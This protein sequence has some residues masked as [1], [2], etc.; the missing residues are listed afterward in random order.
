MSG[1]D[2]IHFL[3]RANVKIFGIKL[4]PVWIVEGLTHIDTKQNIVRF[5]VGF[6]QVV[7]IAGADQGKAHTVG[8]F[9]DACV[10]FALDGNAVVLNLDEEILFAEDFRIPGAKC[11][12]VGLF[13]I[14]NQISKFAGAAS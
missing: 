7:G 4:H 5:G 14:Q 6:G 10:S 3:G 13:V 2:R 1:H 8:N 11:F 12:S 9:D